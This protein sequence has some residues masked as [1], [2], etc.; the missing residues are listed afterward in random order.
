MVSDISN[1]PCLEYYTYVHNDRNDAIL[2]SRIEPDR[3][4]GI[5]IFKE[6]MCI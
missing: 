1:A 4:C 3:R 2:R 5:I 6:I